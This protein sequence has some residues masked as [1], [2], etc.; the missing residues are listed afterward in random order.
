MKT[1]EMDKTRTRILDNRISEIRGHLATISQ[2]LNWIQI[3]LE[4]GKRVEAKP[5][6]NR[7]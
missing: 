3:E 1:K 6:K 2:Q 7:K 4:A 5:R